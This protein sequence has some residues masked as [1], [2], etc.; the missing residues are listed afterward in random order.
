MNVK[1]YVLRASKNG[2][3]GKKKWQTN[4]KETRQRNSDILSSLLDF[5]SYIFTFRLRFLFWLLEV[6]EI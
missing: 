3:T 6:R 4:R 2:Q 5:Y 1:Q